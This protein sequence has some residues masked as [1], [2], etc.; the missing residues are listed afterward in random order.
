MVRVAL[1][2]PRKNMSILMT[3]KSANF[4]GQSPMEVDVLIV[5]KK[6]IGMAPV[7]INA[8]GVD[9]I[10]REV[11]VRTVQSKSTRNKKTENRGMSFQSMPPKKTP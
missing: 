11:G 6:N 8:D 4:A 3:K 10:L 7:T 2:A 1:I 5:L 9:R